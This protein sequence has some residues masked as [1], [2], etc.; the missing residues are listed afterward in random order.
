[1]YDRYFAKDNGE[2]IKKL[3]KEFEALINKEK[4]EVLIDEKISI[5]NHHLQK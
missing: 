4:D 5:L 1:L 3:Y 2:T